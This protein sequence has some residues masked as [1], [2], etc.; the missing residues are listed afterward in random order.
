M[1]TSSQQL[2]AKIRNMT[3]DLS[4]EERSRKSQVLMSNYFM[5]QLL[6]RISISNYRDNFIIKGGTLVS[7][8]IGI[9]ERA[10]KDIDASIEAL[11]LSTE[12]ME[13]VLEDIFSIDIGDNISFSLGNSTNIIEDADYNGIRFMIEAHFEKI[14][15]HFQIDMATNDIIT[16]CAIEY[17]YKLMFENRTI[18]IKA[19]NIETL[20]AEKIQTIVSRG[21]ENTRIK[22][23]YD[24]FM[25]TSTKID[26]DYSLLA[27]AFEATSIKRGTHDISYTIY[28]L[29]NELHECDDII[30]LWENYKQTNYF[31]SN[32][33]WDEILDSINTIIDN[34]Y[35][36]NKIIGKK[37]DYET[38]DTSNDPDAPDI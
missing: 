17:N 8:Y 26:I 35:F 36:K 2:K 27:D 4:I 3:G 5:E 13:K 15:H 22:D 24:I 10:T 9:E 31:V 14:I 11:T 30:K 33:N 38:I 18:P 16:P 21:T 37:S 28:D 7:S 12:N 23:F 32:L 34:D 1:I 19:Y 6:E 20:L 25:L 29:I